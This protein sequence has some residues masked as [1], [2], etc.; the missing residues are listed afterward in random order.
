MGQPYSIQ[1]QRGK[2]KKLPEMMVGQ[3][4]LLKPIRLSMRDLVL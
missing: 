3:H 4:G 1:A 2:Q